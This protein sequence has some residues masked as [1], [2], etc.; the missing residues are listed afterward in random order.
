MLSGYNPEDG[1]HDLAAAADAYVVKSGDEVT[2]LEGVVRTVA[3]Q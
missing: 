1:D 3:G 2:E